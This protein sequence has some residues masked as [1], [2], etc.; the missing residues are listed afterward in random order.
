MGDRGVKPNEVFG[1]SNKFKPEIDQL[2]R[3]PQ[4]GLVS[5]RPMASAN[6]RRQPVNERPIAVRV[7]HLGQLAKLLQPSKDRLTAVADLDQAVDIGL[8]PLG[9]YPL[10]RDLIERFRLDKR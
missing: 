9:C 1:R 8:H 7:H 3:R 4:I 10:S 2:V 6:L 5:R